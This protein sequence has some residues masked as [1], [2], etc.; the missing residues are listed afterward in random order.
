MN[1]AMLWADQ[2]M[3]GKRTYAEVPRRLKPQV[4]EILRDAGLEELI[5]E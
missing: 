2:I 5:T 3:K 4:A 1:M